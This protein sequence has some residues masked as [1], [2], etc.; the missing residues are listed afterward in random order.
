MKRK[1][2][3]IPFGFAMGIAILVIIMNHYYL[4]NKDLFTNRLFVLMLLFFA[5]YGGYNARCASERK[6]D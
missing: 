5:F 1:I 4:Y 2:N 6:E 3:A